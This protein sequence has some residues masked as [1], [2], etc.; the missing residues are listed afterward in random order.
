MVGPSIVDLCTV[1]PRMVDRCIVDRCIVDPRMVDPRMV[2]P[3]TVECRPT[4]IRLDVRDGSDSE[5]SATVSKLLL[6]KPTYRRRR[7]QLAVSG[8]FC[9]VLVHGQQ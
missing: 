5:V 1:D 4:S 2:G 9:P 6:Q 3:C 7:R 8:P